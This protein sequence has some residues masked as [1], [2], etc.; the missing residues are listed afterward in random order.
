[1]AQRA[2]RSVHA[3]LVRIVPTHVRSVHAA[4]VRIVPTHVR[5]VHATDSTLD[6]LI[7]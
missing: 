4:L 2:V 7:E 3:A 6:W 1:M 5:S